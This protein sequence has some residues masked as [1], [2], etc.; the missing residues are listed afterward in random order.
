M[1]WIKALHIIFMV[2]W[3]AGLFYLPRIFVY[4]AMS[5]DH[6]EQE[7]FKIMER[8]LLIMT[9]IGGVLTIVFGTWLLVAWLPTLM[10][11]DWMKWKLGCV[12]I[13]VLYHLYCVKLVADFKHERN[14]RTHK[15]YRLFN[16]IP[17][18]FLFAI[19]ILV[20]VRPI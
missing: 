15:W 4:H 11:L 1:L 18:L 16:E 14:E 8:K 3:F 20:V 12:A 7:T 17:V 5:G 9:H 13:L 6:R 10:S 19:V 2:T